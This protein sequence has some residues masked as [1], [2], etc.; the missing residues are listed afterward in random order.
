MN[1]TLSLRRARLVI[2]RLDRRV[3][4]IVLVVAVSLLGAGL[5]FY[6]LGEWSFWIDELFTIG[7]IQAHFSS[8][9]AIRNNIP[10]AATWL[11][12]SL[13][14]TSGA[15]RILGISEW[16]SRLVP[17]LIG[18]L[19]IPALYL[20]I[21]KVFSSRVGL[22]AALLL[23]ISPWHLT[24]SQNARFYTA[25]LL[26]YSLSLLAFYLGLERNRPWVIVL[27]LLLFYL[28][29]SE[30]LTA[31]FLVP[32]VA[33]YLI[34]LRFLSFGKPP[35][36]RRRILLLLFIP[37]V[38]GCIVEG[39]A[40]VTTGT[41]RLFGDL[42][43][44]LLYR[45]YTP[46]KLMSVISYDIGV[47]LM[48]LATF[49]AYYLLKQ[50]SRIGLLL[51][52]GVVLP[53]VLLLPLSL[54]MFTEDRYVFGTLPGWTVLAAVAIEEVWRQVRQRPVLLAFSII[55][56]LAA[57]A[58]ADDLLYFR[59][60]NGNRRD[61]RGAFSLVRERAQVDDLVVAYWPEFGPYYLGRQI[62]AWDDISPET[63]VQSGKRVWFVVD[64]ETVW[65]DLH[66]K[67][68]I[69]QNAELIDVLYLRLPEDLNLRIYLYD[70]ARAGP[71]SLSE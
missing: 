71:P 60:N 44:F 48:C 8:A 70:P 21:K 5:R 34:L 10:P 50:R 53:L 37:V 29:L 67:R 25:M 65:G 11:P 49:G 33:V 19:S 24:W 52:I 38:A 40:L 31:A 42:S 36:L 16:S 7:R 14:L 3:I 46:L 28:A 58:A 56:L 27:G 23:A 22:I 17:A 20:P 30:R 1:T 45:N 2:G 26:L 57:D 68:W 9:E 35:G 47:P 39:H 59:V 61:W 63:V 51:V 66:K 13:L 15:L 41:S 32:T 54:F 18:I 6:K 69:E 55:A 64:S 62:I 12:L 4:E 43:W